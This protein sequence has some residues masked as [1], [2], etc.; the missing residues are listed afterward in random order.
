VDFGPD[1]NLLL[2]CGRDTHTRVWDLRSG[3]LAV[4]PLRH[5]RT[6]CA[7]RFGLDGAEVITASDDG[8]LRRWDW[9]AGRLLAS[10]H[11]HKLGFSDF[12]LTR[13]QRWLVTTGIGETNVVD[14]RTGA[15][16][17]PPLPGSQQQLNLRVVVPHNNSRAVVSGFSGSLLGHDLRAVLTPTTGSI[18]EITLRAELASGQRVHETGSLVQLSAT[19]WS[20]R[21]EQL[22]RD[23]PTTTKAKVPPAP[24]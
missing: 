23:Y 20:E 2:T 15:P 5:P 3:K 10:Y 18:D 11:L 4:H 13:D 21:W 12:T 16:M 22:S 19:E 8:R 6:V 17:A 24:R 14:C 9:R 1:P 7:A